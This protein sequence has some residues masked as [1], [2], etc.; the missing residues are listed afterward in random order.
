M[1]WERIQYGTMFVCEVD[2][3]IGKMILLSSGDNW[4]SVSEDE[5]G[6]S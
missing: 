6:N 1:F 4:E 5:C 3:M 2:K